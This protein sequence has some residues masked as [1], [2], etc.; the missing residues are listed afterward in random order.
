MKI[1]Y[2]NRVKNRNRDTTISTASCNDAIGVINQLNGKEHT[3]VLLERDDTS[4]LM[5]GGGPDH[6][7]I[8]LQ[9]GDRN[10]ALKKGGENT[11]SFVEIC[12]GGQF[13][14]YPGYLGNTK[15]TAIAAIKLFFENSEDILDWI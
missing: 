13:G 10:L 8:T 12:A 4:Q 2:D 6:F 9:K 1:I 3:L 15:D 5:V 14:D 7:I 11:E